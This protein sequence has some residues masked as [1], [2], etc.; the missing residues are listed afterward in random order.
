ML[1]EA[2]ATGMPRY[3]SIRCLANRAAWAE[4]PRA[5][6]INFEPSLTLALSES[7]QLQCRLAIETRSTGY[8]VRA[9]EFGDD[10][11]RRRQRDEGEPDHR[12][13]QSAHIKSALDA[14]VE[15][16]GAE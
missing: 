9:R 14:D 11:H 4:L 1:G 7:C 5:Q 6:V 10:Q 16:A 13:S 15:H 12:A 3:S 2:D 8:Q